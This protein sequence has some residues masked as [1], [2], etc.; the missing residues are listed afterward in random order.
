MIHIAQE[1]G[2]SSRL[3][4]FTK[5]EFEADQDGNNFVSSGNFG[6]VRKYQHKSLGTVVVKHFHITG[7]AKDIAKR[8]QM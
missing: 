1:D 5:E 8:W 2:F 7:N 6:K 3:V 4:R